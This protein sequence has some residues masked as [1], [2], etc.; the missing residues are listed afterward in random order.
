MLA[1][2]S[3]TLMNTGRDKLDIYSIT[4]VPE[5][6]K[7]SRIQFSRELS[8]ACVAIETAKKNEIDARVFFYRVIRNNERNVS[9]RDSTLTSKNLFFLRNS[10]RTKQKSQWR[11]ETQIL[12][13]CQWITNLRMNDAKNL[14]QDERLD[15]STPADRSLTMNKN[16]RQ[17]LL[18]I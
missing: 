14:R 5:R 9:F 18:Q 12:I 1:R 2:G 7:I 16:P 11:F 3:C 10:T 4:S 8:D 17:E 6:L 15:D 13:L